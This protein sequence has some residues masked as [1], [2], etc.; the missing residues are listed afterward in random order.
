MFSNYNIIQITCDN[1]ATCIVLNKI[2]DKIYLYS[3]NSGLNLEVHNKKK[4][5]YSAYISYPIEQ[6]NHNKILFIIS[7]GNFYNNIKNYDKPN[8]YILYEIIIF[9]KFYNKLFIDD[10]LISNISFK[11][12][13]EEKEIQDLII[14]FNDKLDHRSKK[15]KEIQT[16]T[17]KIECNTYYYPLFHE[18]LKKIVSNEIININD[19]QKKKIST[20]HNTHN[21]NKNIFDKLILHVD[22]TKYIYYLNNPDHVL[23]FLYI[24]HYVLMH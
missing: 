10:R 18:I 4:D 11:I 21:L 24:G 17:F 14:F 6:I 19:V 2:N 20:L 22:E 13:S 1:H 7:I 9:I 5:K 16:F 8:E 15:C 12:N 23:G 3:F